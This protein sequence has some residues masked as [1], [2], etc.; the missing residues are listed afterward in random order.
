MIILRGLHLKIWVH[1]RMPRRAMTQRMEMFLNGVEQNN[2]INFLQYKNKFN[3]N[4]TFYL[5]AIPP[6]KLHF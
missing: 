4:N 5:E 3:E 2:F 6:E 1:L